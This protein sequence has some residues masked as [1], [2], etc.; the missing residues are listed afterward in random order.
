MTT[1]SIVPDTSEDISGG[2]AAQYNEAPNEWPV[3][4]Y[5]YSVSKGRRQGNEDRISVSPCILGRPGQNLF[6]VYDGHSGSRASEHCKKDI[7]QR[8]TQELS[9]FPGGL[10]AN[11]AL[12]VFN[13]V[14]KEADAQFC[15][16]ANSAQWED[17]TTCCTVLVAGL[18]LFCASCG[19]SR[20]MLCRMQ[21]PIPLSKEH[22]PSDAAEE[23]RI[24]RAG[25]EVKQAGGLA[26]VNG[27]LATSRAIGDAHLKPS[28]ISDP[29]VSHRQLTRGDDFV[30]LG[31]DGLFDY[32]G[33]NTICQTVYSSPDAKTAAQTLVKLAMHHGSW[34]NVSA[35]VV[36]LRSFFL[37]KHQALQT[38]SR[39]TPLNMPQRIKSMADKLLS[40][41]DLW[42][43]PEVHSGWL[44]KQ[45]RGSM[46]GGKRWQKRWF[47]LHAVT[48]KAAADFSVHREPSESVTQVAFVLHYHDS[49]DASLSQNPRKPV[50]I[51]PV[52]GVSREEHLDK[53]DH[54][55]LS[56]YE[57]SSGDVFIVAAPSPREADLWV[58]KA[59]E[60]FEKH[61]FARPKGQ[62]SGSS[63]KKL[64]RSLSELELND[65]NSV[66]QSDGSTA[67]APEGL[68]ENGQFTGPVQLERSDTGGLQAIG[69][70]WH[71]TATEMAGMDAN[72]LGLPRAGYVLNDM[73]ARA[74]GLPPGSAVVR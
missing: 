67:A 12:S 69:G 14:F 63:S 64:V 24:K 34:D 15:A 58:G 53:P 52:M 49:Q 35:I 68:V 28:V 27:V 65:P 59:E 17:G 8:I 42:M 38:T 46:I 18:D 41:L 29:Y 44:S 47:V 39:V 3:P 11:E 74:F 4:A 45:S 6:G 25:G 51:D 26:R 50:F 72:T 22:K 61:G 48:G 23:A 37:E 16:E 66:K 32:V 55:C 21:A 40:G 9:R 31:S 57:A 33:P 56:V 19:D 13:K 2:D 70:G 20:A 60:A 71:V 43:V 5:G 1:V 7:P 36:D 73:Q 62:G 54:A 10:P 30:V